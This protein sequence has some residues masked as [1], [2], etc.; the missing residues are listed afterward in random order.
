MFASPTLSNSIAS[1]FLAY[2]LALNPCGDRAW[3]ATE[4]KRH[5]VRCKLC[6]H[7]TQLRD[8]Q[9][10][11]HSIRLPPP[12]SCVPS[13]PDPFPPPAWCP[14]CYPPPHTFRLDPLL[15]CP[16]FSLPLVPGGGY[17]PPPPPPQTLP[18][19]LGGDNRR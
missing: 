1:R 13:T 7:L 14:K 18:T 16:A 19:P 11:S 6:Q 2:L 10:Y 5:D 8:P 4:S 9:L 12:P 15:P 17:K 3:D